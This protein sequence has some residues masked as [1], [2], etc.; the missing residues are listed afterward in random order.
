MFDLEMTLIVSGLFP[1]YYVYYVLIVID[2]GLDFLSSEVSMATKM[3]LVQCGVKNEATFSTMTT[4]E[5]RGHGNEI[6]SKQMDILL[7]NHT[8]KATAYCHEGNCGNIHIRQ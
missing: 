1:I 3:A 2:E 8:Q 7:D 6:S 4:K 5:L